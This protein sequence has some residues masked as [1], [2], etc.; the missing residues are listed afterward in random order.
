MTEHEEECDGIDLDSCA[1]VDVK[2]EN[3]ELCFPDEIIEDSGTYYTITSCEDG[4][5]QLIMADD[6]GRELLVAPSSG[7]E[8][9]STDGNDDVMATLTSEA[10]LLSDNEGQ[11]ICSYTA[12]ANDDLAG[13]SMQTVAGMGSSTG[14]PAYILNLPYPLGNLL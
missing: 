14:Q 7:G 8:C 2:Q 4:S 5:R 3:I 12:T 1:G 6:D 13:P 9:S 11:I 10:Q